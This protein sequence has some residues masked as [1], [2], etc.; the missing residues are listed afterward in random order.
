MKEDKKILFKS[1]IISA[2]ITVL[3]FLFKGLVE[4]FPHLPDTG[5]SWYY[6]K[7]PEAK[8]WPRVTSWGLYI[9]HQVLAWFFIYKLVKEKRGNGNKLNKYNWALLWTNFIFVLLHMVQSYIW[10]DG[11]AQDT[12]VWSS[13]GSVIVM[14][15]LLLIM[16]NS[17]RG[18]FFGKKL[19]LFKDGTK[20]IYKYHGYY[21]AWAVIFTFW[22]H[23]ME[24]TTGHL[25][26][27]FYLFLLMIQM[28]MAYTKVHTNRYWTFTVE[29]LVLFHGTAVA[30][31]G[32]SAIWSMFA[33]GF[34]FIFIVTQI[35]GLKLG[36]IAILI[37]TITYGVLAV[38][39]YSGM[40]F[41]SRSLSD[42]HQIT[43][44]PIIEYLLVF[45]FI[46]LAQLPSL[47]KK[48]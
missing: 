27:F 24:G 29:V 21:I 31:V 47:F 7:L 16:E 2:I 32:G 19:K 11:L 12:P 28:S 9:I 15:V 38:I 36:K 8:F 22:F 40:F 10:Y 43:W 1:I 5:A 20:R 14:L 3:I 25:F 45:V 30:A 4:G 34:G 33:F 26:G 42:I 23:P 48:K 44:I 35:Y 6:W 41:G 39:V 13:Q 46:A 18:L 17:R 37:A